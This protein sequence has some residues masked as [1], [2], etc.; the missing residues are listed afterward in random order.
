LGKEWKGGNVKLHS[1]GGQKINFL[2][3]ELEKY[4]NDEKKI[5]AFTD[6][7]IEVFFSSK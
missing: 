6:R 4:K 7:F 3:N 5:I 1:G 2:V